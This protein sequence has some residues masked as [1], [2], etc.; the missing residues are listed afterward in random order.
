MYEVYEKTI[1]NICKIVHTIYNICILYMK[2]RKYIFCNIRTGM[3][4]ANI[5][6]WKDFHFLQEPSF[7]SNFIRIEDSTMANFGFIPGISSC[8]RKTPNIL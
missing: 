4:A 8:R 6:I 3:H 7:I 2:S 5:Q 1:Y